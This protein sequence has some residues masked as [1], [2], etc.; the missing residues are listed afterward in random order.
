VLIFVEEAAE[1]VVSFD[2]EYLGWRAVGEWPCGSCL[3][4]AA[5]RTVIVVVALELAQHG[6]GVSLVDEEKTVE[7]FAADGADE[8]FGDRVRPR[9]THRCLEDLDVDGGE[10]GVEGGGE[11]AVVGR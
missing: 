8:A 2:L 9:R 10:D 7:E 11:L 6:C 1:A 4:Q 5:V 3:S